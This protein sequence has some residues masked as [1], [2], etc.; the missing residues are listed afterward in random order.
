MKNCITY[1]LLFSSLLFMSAC[2]VG[3]SGGGEPETVML[4]VT[5]NMEEAG[6]ISP[7]SGQ[8]NSGDSVTVEARPYNGY[9]FTE[10]TGDR[11]SSANPFTFVI[12]EDTDLIANFRATSSE[13]RMNLSVADTS[14]TLSTL[15]FGQLSNA[16][17]DIDNEDF[18]A[19][20]PPPEDNLHAYFQNEKDL[21]WDFRSSTATSITWNLQLQPGL[22]DS[23]HF[24]WTLNKT[25]LNGSITLRSE[26]S[27]IEVDMVQAQ[28]LSIGTGDANHLLIEYQLGN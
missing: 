10:W 15:R 3:G 25:I 5:S 17:D 12:E 13:Y 14:D 22:T 8:F 28:E 23:L 20:P 11:T 9:G 27:S 21:F 2:G 6:S 16:T 1:I 18:E 19:P 4:N 24:F 7:S 26:D